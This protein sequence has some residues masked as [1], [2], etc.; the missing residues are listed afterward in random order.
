MYFDL[1]ISDEASEVTVITIV[2]VHIQINK[3]EKLS[4]FIR[5]FCVGLC[6]I[7]SEKVTYCF[8][9]QQQQISHLLNVIM[10]YVGERNLKHICNYNPK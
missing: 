10:S 9:V 8:A 6:E 1:V 7:L 3:Y 5:Q 4:G 2:L